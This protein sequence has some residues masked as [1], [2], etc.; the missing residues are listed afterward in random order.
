MIAATSDAAPSRSRA[1][2]GALS[3]T[4]SA[5]A[6]A[7]TDHAMSGM[8]NEGPRHRNYDIN[9]S[10]GQAERL[11]AAVYPAIGNGWRSRTT[12]PVNVDP[13]VPVSSTVRYVPSML[14]S[15][16]TSTVL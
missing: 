2:G 16:G 11:V 8:P 10:R 7:N 13:V 9:S 3:A 12:V 1:S 14:A 6:Y 15:P 4:M 5:P